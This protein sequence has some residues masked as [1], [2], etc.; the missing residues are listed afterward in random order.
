MHAAK[1]QT[2]VLENEVHPLR[3]PS[4]PADPQPLRQATRPDRSPTVAT[5]RCGGGVRRSLADADPDRESDGE[6]PSTSSPL[7]DDP[8]IWPDPSP[9]ADWWDRVLGQPSTT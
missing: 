8:I 6:D 2:F 4:P 7:P 3:I 9:L 5:G 1:E